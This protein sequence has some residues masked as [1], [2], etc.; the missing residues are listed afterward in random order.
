MQAVK[1]E[2]L[3]PRHSTQGLDA[4]VS[5][6][7][8]SKVR[9]DASKASDAGWFWQFNVNDVRVSGTP[10]TSPTLRWVMVMTYY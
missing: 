5:E 7:W 6:P 2:A 4:V 3:G 9:Q 8:A 1:A 10:L